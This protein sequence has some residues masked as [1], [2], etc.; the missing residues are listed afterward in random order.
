MLGMQKWTFPIGAPLAV[1]SVDSVIWGLLT[2]DMSGGPSD[3]VEIP[4]PLFVS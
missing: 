4:M 1:P 2:K 3:N